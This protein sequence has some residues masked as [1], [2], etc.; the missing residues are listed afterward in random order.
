MVKF[1]LYGEGN[2]LIKFYFRLYVVVQTSS[3]G[4]IMKC[5]LY[6]FRLNGEV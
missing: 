1:E 3:L 2:K 4:Y 5:K 6:K